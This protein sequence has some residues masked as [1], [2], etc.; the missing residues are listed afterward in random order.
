MVDP[1]LALPPPAPGSR[2]RVEADRLVTGYHYLC[3]RGARKFRRAGLDGHDLEQVAAI[4]LIK[5][6]RNFQVAAGT[7]FEA[8]AWAL[9]VGELMHYVRDHERH[10]RIPRRLRALEPTYTRAHESCVSRLG[11]EPSDA[12]IARAMGVLPPTVAELRRARDWSTVA[13]IDEAALVPADRE[14]TIQIEDRLVF[15]DAF[16]RLEPLERR[17][18]IGIYVLGFTRLELARRLQVPPRRILRVLRGALSSM[19]RAWNG[20]RC[21]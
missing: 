1:A 20:E 19:Q 12:E 11:R 6:S 10:I 2:D 5:A 8:Y 13:S 17:V 21:S 14:S 16:A 9:I 4:G 7:P 15:G 3:R 18:L